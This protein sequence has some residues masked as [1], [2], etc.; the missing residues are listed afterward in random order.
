MLKKNQFEQVQFEHVQIE[1]VQIELVQIEHVQFE[2][3]QIELLK[4]AKN[5][6]FASSDRP[7]AFRTPSTRSKLRKDSGGRK[8]LE[9]RSTLAKKI[10]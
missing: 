3:V 2:H 4:S 5:S 6:N 9:F 10:C 1:Q 7:I 8:K